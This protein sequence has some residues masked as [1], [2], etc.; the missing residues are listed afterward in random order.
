MASATTLTCPA[1]NAALE[2]KPS[3]FIG[4]DLGY[5]GKCGCTWYANPAKGG[6][7][8]RLDRKG[9]CETFQDPLDPPPTR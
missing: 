3:L 5:C 8:T 1:C 6:R 2:S 7:L 9:V 4:W